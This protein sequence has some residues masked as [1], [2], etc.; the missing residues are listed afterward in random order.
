ML[1]G[2]DLMNFQSLLPCVL[3]FVAKYVTWKLSFP[4][5][6]FVHLLM[7]GCPYTGAC[8]CEKVIGA[9]RLISLFD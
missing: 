6:L 3:V 2:G 4:L 9:D 7:Q 1:Q 8:F 5:R